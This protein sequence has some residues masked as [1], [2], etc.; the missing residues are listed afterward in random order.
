MTKYEIESVNASSARALTVSIGDIRI[1][2]ISHEPDLMLQ[3]GRATRRFLVNNDDADVTVRAGWGDLRHPAAGYETFDSGG[4][5]RLYQPN[6]HYLFRFTS[7]VFGTLPYKQACFSSDFTSGEIVLHRDYFDH[8]QPVNALE[9]PL[10]ELLMMNLLT[11]GRG[12]EVHAC[13]VEDSDGRGY[14]FVGQS[15]AGK[16]TTARLWHKAGRIHLLSDD[17]IILRCLEGRIWMYGTPWHGEADFA[18]STRTPLTQIFFLDRG[19]NNEAVPLRSP[20]AVAR[21]MACSFV[22]FYNASALGH[23]LAFFEHVT[24]A[25]P[26]GEL[27]FAPDERV[28]EFVREYT[29]V[30]RP[31]VQAVC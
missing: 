19:E 29:H 10:D 23:V 5:W 28:L 21:L 15:G 3:V 17:R 9:Y 18:S 22:P 20:E 30:Y 12:V 13:G 27:R 24:D 25:V 2:I 14:L 11:L 4:V 26:C 1:A 16:T 8:R 7:P 6:S 31:W